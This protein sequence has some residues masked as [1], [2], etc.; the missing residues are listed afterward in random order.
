MRFLGYTL[1]S[2]ADA[3]APEPRPRAVRTDGC[4]VEEATKAGVIVA[5]GGIAPTSEGVIV[6]LEDGEYTVLDG[7]FTEAKEIVGGWAFLECRDLPEAVEWVRAPPPH[8]RGVPPRAERPGPGCT[9]ADAAGAFERAAALA[10][11]EPE[12]GL[13]EARARAG[14]ARAGTVVPPS[15]SANDLARDGTLRRPPGTQP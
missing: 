9:D 7:P 12:R 5:T 13:T 6:S 1:A 15:P 10:R 14:R 4:F 3:P 2:E 8:L 11:N